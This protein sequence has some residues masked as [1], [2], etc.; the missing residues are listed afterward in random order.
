MCQGPWEWFIF[1]A[2]KKKEHFDLTCSQNCISFQLF[3]SQRNATNDHIIKTWSNIELD[4]FSSDC[5]VFCSNGTC[6]NEI[7]SGIN[8]LYF[9]LFHFK[10]IK[11]LY[12]NCIKAKFNFN[13]FLKDINL[14]FFSYRGSKLAHPRPG[15]QQTR[16]C[17]VR[18]PCLHG[19]QLCSLARLPRRPER[20]QKGNHE[21][22]QPGQARRDAHHR[23]QKLRQHSRQRYGSQ[24]QHLLQRK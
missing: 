5:Q 17:R 7:K 8:E 20:S 6:K 19:Q 9:Q 18:C 15:H 11:G 4:H 2:L 21:L 24:K 12:K 3:R 22:L 16:G 13:A 23:S 1:I 14:N 10:S